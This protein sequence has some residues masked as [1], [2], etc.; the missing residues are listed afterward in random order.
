MANFVVVIDS[1]IERRSR[2]IKTIEPLLPLVEGLI[3]TKCSI[4]DFCAIWASQERAPISHKADNQSAAVIWGDAINGASE[5]ID[6]TQLRHLWGN[7]TDHMPDALD[8]F[9]AAVVYHPDE[10][11]IVGADLLGLFPIYY[12]AAGDVVLVGSSP[13]LFRYHP[14]FRMEFNPAGLVGILLLM[15]M[16]DGQT[17]LRDVRR[18]AAGHLLRWRSGALPKEVQQYELPVSARYF[19]LPFSAHVDLLDQALDEAITRH[20]PSSQRYSLL[21]SGGLDSRML[22]GFLKR[23][24]IDVE[25]LTW[26]VPTDFDLRCATAVARTLGFRHHTAELCVKWEHVANGLSSPA[27]W[28]DHLHV[29]ELAPSIVTGYVMDPIVGGGHIMWAYSSSDRS[30]SFETFFARANCFGIQPNILKKLLRREVFGDLVQETVARIKTVYE[31]YSE[32]E[33]QRPWCFDLH[34][35][36]RFYVGIV[37][38]MLSFGAW[39]VQPVVDRQVLATAGG[40]PAAA[41]AGRRAQV[42]LLCRQFPQLASLP[43]DR[44]SFNTRP[45]RPRLRYLLW[46]FLQGPLRRLQEQTNLKDHPRLERRYYHRTTGFNGPGWM[47]I[48]RQAD[49]YRER[50]LD[51]VN[52]D[53]LDELLPA[54]D[55]P[56][57]EEAGFGLKSLLGFMIWSKDH[58]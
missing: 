41:L 39:P 15:N 46:E 57:P 27:Y 34:H 38:W 5:R 22:G 56:W 31:S 3:T 35:R 28:S 12:Y 17:L 52:K 14:T 33:S 55:V 25:A 40:M 48:R 23:S 47:A 54:P 42:E 53:V 58:L 37:P 45:L 26:G 18:L 49:P 30:L 36:Q 29:R 10:G 11:L 43:L 6:A 7:L 50:V 9:H 44:S 16:F 8:G 21:L 13:E 19:D 2:F 1:D 20:V 51:Y 4:G 24:G 32:L